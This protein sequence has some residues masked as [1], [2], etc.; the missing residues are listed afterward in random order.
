MKFLFIVLLLFSTSLYSNTDCSRHPI[1]CQIT[2][3]KPNIDKTYA[4][5]LSNLIYKMHKKYH[6][7]SRLFTA[8]LMQ[9]SGYRLEA[10]GCQEGIRKKTE[11]EIQ[12]E[13][14]SNIRKSIGII[15]YT[16]SKV[17][18]DFGISQIYFK[19]AK[20]W[21]FD[22]ERLTTDLE[23]SV[24]AGAKVLHDV[25]ERFEARDNDWYTRYNCGF[26]GSTKRD[27]C[28]IYKKL[29]KRYL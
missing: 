28:Q 5:E 6:I 8:I 16:K 14:Y 21:G 18:T 15:P 10:K 25:M 20:G 2:K 23:Y 29:I 27:T 26:R 3:N 4:M 9:E 17:C 11:S 7:P 1:F 19:T 12:W 24:E 13:L 22:I